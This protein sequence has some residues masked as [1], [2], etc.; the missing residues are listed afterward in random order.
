MVLALRFRITVLD[1]QAQL[2]LC[3]QK[4]LFNLRLL[5]NLPFFLS[6]SRARVLFLSLSLSLL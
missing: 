4:L 6:L 1:E 5:F 2:F 3:D